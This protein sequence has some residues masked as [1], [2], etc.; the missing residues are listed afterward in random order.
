LQA[1]LQAAQEENQDLREQV[2]YLQAELNKV[3]AAASVKPEHSPGVVAELHAKLKSAEEWAATLESET[4]GWRERWKLAEEKAKSF[5]E[6]LAAKTRELE[7]EFLEK[8]KSFEERLVAKSKEL[9]A[10]L[11]RNFPVKPNH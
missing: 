5:E 3:K 7:T 1:S 11:R 6:R 8:A 2:R 4:A 10:A 9:E